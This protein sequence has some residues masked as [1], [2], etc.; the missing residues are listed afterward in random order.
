LISSPEALSGFREA[1]LLRRVSWLEEEVRRLHE[2]LAREQA[3]S[4]ELSQRVKELEQALPKT[5][6]KR[7]WHFW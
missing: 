3:I 6:K 7:W 1:E 5:P 2:A 4:Y